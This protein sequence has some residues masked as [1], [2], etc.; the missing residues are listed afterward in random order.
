MGSHRMSSSAAE[1]LAWV[2]IAF[3]ALLV[4]A[5]LWLMVTEFSYL[6]RTPTRIVYH[7]LARKY[8]NKWRKKEYA[9]QEIT[10]RLFLEPLR[11]ALDESPSSAL[12]DLACGSGRMTFLALR[13]DWFRGKVD[14][15]DFSPGMLKRFGQTLAACTPQQRGRV[16]VHNQDLDQWQAPAGKRYDAVTLMEAAEFLADFPR[17]VDELNKCLKPSGLFLLTKPGP[18]RTWFFP[19]RRQKARALT[20]LLKEKGFAR[21]EIIPWTADYHV[22]HAWRQEEPPAAGG[23]EGQTS[24]SQTV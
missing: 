17:L 13:S 12:L 3:V 20:E 11:Q 1:I 6:G 19:W 8:E 23:V 24:S 15:V 18:W 10:R 7:F 9:S 16:Q 14:A 4:L 22:V 21:V 5:A 2:I